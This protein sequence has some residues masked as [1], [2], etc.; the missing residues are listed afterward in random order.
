MSRILKKLKNRE[1]IARHEL[2]EAADAILTAAGNE[3]LTKKFVPG[4]R[5]L[6]RKFRGQR[7]ARYRKK[8]AESIREQA[9]RREKIAVGLELYRLES[10]IIK[11][12]QT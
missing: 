4:E 8:T 5:D 2:R 7:L 6:V 10:K 9:E 1:K 12:E 11:K 3:R